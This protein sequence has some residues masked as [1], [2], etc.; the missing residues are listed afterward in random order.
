[1]KSLNTAGKVIHADVYGNKFSIFELKRLLSI[2]IVISLL[3]NQMKFHLLIF[4]T[5]CKFHENLNNLKL[6]KSFSSSCCNLSVL[7]FKFQYNMKFPF[8]HFQLRQ[9][10][11]NNFILNFFALQ[12]WDLA[13]WENK[14]SSSKKIF[15]FR[16]LKGT[17]IHVCS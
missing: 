15:I 5:Y 4:F 16:I 12:T 8:E 10:Q 6:K 2:M 3:C 11:L 9:C 14:T 17:S 7:V 13:E 1:M